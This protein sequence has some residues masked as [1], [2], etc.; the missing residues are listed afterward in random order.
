MLA[1]PVPAPPPVTPHITS[2]THAADLLAFQ[3]KN[4]TPH[5]PACML[6][7]GCVAV[8]AAPTDDIIQAAFDGY[9]SA[10]IEYAADE[11]SVPS[12]VP[13]AQLVQF[14]A[15]HNG[16]S[17]HEY[18]HGTLRLWEA[19]LASLAA[20]LPPVAGTALLATAS[21]AKKGGVVLKVQTRPD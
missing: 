4:Q 17:P 21:E 10:L 8:H 15:D 12:S 14:R 5:R 11:R 2:A 18:H 20:D 6:V 13:S 1:T 7:P 3:R 19:Y 16:M 9:N